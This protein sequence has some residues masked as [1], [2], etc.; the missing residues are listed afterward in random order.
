MN[1][2]YFSFSFHPQ[3]DDGEGAE[4]GEE[5]KKMRRQLRMCM[6]TTSAT[7]FGECEF[8]KDSMYD[9]NNFALFVCIG[10]IAMFVSGQLM[11]V[12]IAPILFCTVW[13]NLAFLKRMYP[14]M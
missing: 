7:S 10:M 11:F 2:F 14:S 3:K 13:A 4:R 1:V 8:A 12:K 6:K 5:M 9:V